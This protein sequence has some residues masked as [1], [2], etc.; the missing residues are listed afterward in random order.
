MGRSDW[1]TPALQGRGE[2]G[3]QGRTLGLVL[4]QGLSRTRREPVVHVSGAVDGLGQ[5]RLPCVLGMVSV[6]D[7][8]A[9]HRVGHGIQEGP[10]ERLGRTTH[11]AGK[12]VVHRAVLGDHAVDLA[13]AVTLGGALD[14]VASVPIAL[15][16]AL[17]VGVDV[18]DGVAVAAVGQVALHEHVVG[19]HGAQFERAVDLGVDD[20]HVD[21]LDP[22]GPRG[23]RDTQG[24]GFLD[25][26]R[27]GHV[28]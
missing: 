14:L 23:H 19:T 6:I 13:V 26:V 8:V 2:E 18:L 20:G 9:L 28:S 7:Q 25:V 27:L 5:A 22:L 15:G 17:V 3:V 10:H 16:L 21:V 1:L 12:L 11:G 4:R 24:Q